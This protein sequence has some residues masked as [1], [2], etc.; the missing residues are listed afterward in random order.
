MNGHAIDGE[1]QVL[2]S[3]HLVGDL[4]NAEGRILRIRIFSA[5]PN[6]R[7]NV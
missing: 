6:C 7:C 2:R 1:G 4:A 5:L 3:G